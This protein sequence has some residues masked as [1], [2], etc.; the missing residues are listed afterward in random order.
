[1]QH[2]A[3]PDWTLA[4]LADLRGTEIPLRVSVVIASEADRAAVESAVLEDA[5]FD[6]RHRIEFAGHPPDTWAT[7]LVSPVCPTQGVLAATL[8]RHVKALWHR[9]EV[10]V[11]LAV[12]PGRTDSSPHPGGWLP[13][14]APEATPGAID[15]RTLAEALLVSGGPDPRPSVVLV[16]TTSLPR[17]QLPHPPCGEVAATGLAEWYRF[18]VRLLAE[19]PAWLDPEAAGIVGS[20]GPDALGLWKEWPSIIEA[21]REIGLLDRPDDPSRALVGWTRRAAALLR[22]RFEPGAP[23]RDPATA[24]LAAVVASRWRSL[25]DEDTGGDGPGGGGVPLLHS[26]PSVGAG[27]GADHDWLPRRREARPQPLHT[28][29]VVAPGYTTRH[30]GIVALHRLCDR[31]NAIGYDAFVHPIGFSH[32]I[33]PDWLTPLLR[34]RSARDMVAIYPETVSGN[35]LGADRVVRWLLNRPGRIHGNAMDEGPDDLLVSF[36]EQVSDQHPVL[37]VPLIDPQVFFPKDRPGTGSLL[38]IGKGELPAG[39]NRSGTQLITNDWPRDRAHFGQVLRSADVLYTCDWLTSVIDESLMCGTPV[40][41]I[42]EQE[43]SRREITLRPGMAW[44]GD[45]LDVARGDVVEYFGRCIDAA[46]WVDASVEEFVRLVNEHFGA[47]VEV[48]DRS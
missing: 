46:G 2:D 3:G 32:E 15:G 17:G 31:L 40:V 47:R 26:L 5:G 44:D 7:P 39:F 43:W 13:D 8:N 1:M 21:G 27:T 16:R 11:S 9:P 12:P 6:D 29:V 42:G 38:W 20:A 25:G 28:F 19:G 18:L 35:E 23:P 41:L 10:T 36:S 33:R 45:D 37:S 48:G 24:E 14:R 34:G 22:D 30:G 4:A